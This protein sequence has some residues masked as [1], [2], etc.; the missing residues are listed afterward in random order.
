MS[1][2]VVVHMGCCRVDGLC[3]EK[4]L[5]IPRSPGGFWSAVSNDGGLGKGLFGSG[6]QV[7]EVVVLSSDLT[8]GR[9]GR[10]VCH[11]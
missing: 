2:S 7:E 5:P 3:G 8:E 1:C 11:H 10:C 9:E 4:G 6:R